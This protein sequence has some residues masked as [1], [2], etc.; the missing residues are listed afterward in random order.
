LAITVIGA[1]SRGFV[2]PEILKIHADDS[3]AVN[4]RLR[5][6]MRPPRHADIPMKKSF[7]LKLN[8]AFCGLYD[9]FTSTAE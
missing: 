3:R 1:D 7:L 2:T 4:F 8:D 9:Y 6:G 5:A